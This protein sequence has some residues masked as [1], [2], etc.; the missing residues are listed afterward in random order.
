MRKKTRNEVTGTALAAHVG[1]TRQTIYNYCNRSV[2]AR[3]E[4]GLFDRDKCRGQILAH[5]RNQAAVQAGNSSDNLATARADLARA[6][7]EAVEWKNARAKSDFVSAEAV[8]QLLKQDFA[9]HRKVLL[10]WVSGLPKM[11]EGQTAPAM[12][13]I[14]EEQV[15][16]VLTRLSDPRT[17]SK[18]RSTTA[19]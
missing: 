7:R 9:T 18:A 2:I 19:Q 10:T 14:I 16:A 13:V 11:L 17:Y 5:L 4:N 3:L 8:I 1:C 15:F 6:Q 12:E